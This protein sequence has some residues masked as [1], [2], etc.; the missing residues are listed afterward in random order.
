[1][2]VI[3]QETIGHPR[4]PPKTTISSEKHPLFYR[5]FPSTRFPFTP[6]PV[7]N[8]RSIT[9]NE[10]YQNQFT[11][12][13]GPLQR[14]EEGRLILPLGQE[15]A[16]LP[17][18]LDPPLLLLA[19]PS[20]HFIQAWCLLPFFRS[21]RSCQKQKSAQAERERDSKQVFACSFRGAAGALLS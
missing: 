7:Q 16:A 6:F 17:W 18:L 1:M 11:K 14:K 5:S 15:A 20:L 4:S 2:F 9:F 19:T 3:W 13:N 12:I 8:V 21:E 10:H